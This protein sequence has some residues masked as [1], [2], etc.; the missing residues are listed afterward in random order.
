MPKAVAVRSEASLQWEDVEGAQVMRV[1][2]AEGEHVWPQV[3]LMRVPHALYHKFSQDHGWF[4][5]FVNKHHVFSKDVIV[6]GPCV[7][8]SSLGRKEDSQD[9]VLTLVHG[10]KST[11]IV[12]AVPQLNWE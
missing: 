12:S 7:A 10:K 8:L 9:L 11:M 4:M 1:W 2:Q 3:S 6:V 5:E